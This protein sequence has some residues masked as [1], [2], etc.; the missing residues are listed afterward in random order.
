VDISNCP[1]FE[2]LR[3]STDF[4]DALA[5]P[6][7]N[8]FSIIAD[9]AVTYLQADIAI[10]N[11]VD[12]D[13]SLRPGLND[14][15]A[16]T[17][18]ASRGDGKRHSISASELRNFLD[19]LNARNSGFDSYA[20]IPLRSVGGTSFGSL[21]VLSHEARHASDQQLAVLRNLAR[22]IVEGVELRLAVFRHLHA[23]GEAFS[24]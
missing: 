11:F 2:L 9:L 1:D 24:S 14:R 6:D 4:L 22:L 23:V 19:P 5:T 15:P 10:I 12:P 20:E 3:E 16:V 21:V 8:S 17:S 7:G 13:G 18:I